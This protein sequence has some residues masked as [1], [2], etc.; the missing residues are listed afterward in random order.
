MKK[1][2]VIDATTVLVDDRTITVENG[3][4]GSAFTAQQARALAILLLKAADLAEDV[5]CREN[6]Q[7]ACR[8][9]KERR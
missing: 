3:I 2:G 7:A 9:Y 6:F 4:A 5:C 8:H 1:V